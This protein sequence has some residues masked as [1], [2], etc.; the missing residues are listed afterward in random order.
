MKKKFTLR[1][2]T[3]GKKTVLMAV[4][5]LVLSAM[6]SAQSP[7]SNATTLWEENFGAGTEASSHPDA[8]FNYNPTG[9]LFDERTYRVANNLQQKIEWH[10]SADHTGNTNGNMLVVNGDAGDF[11]SHTIN[12][13]AG[14][15]SGS[16]YFRHFVINANVPYACFGNPL[17]AQV[18]LRAEY[19]DG[20]GN[21]V[22]MINS[23]YTTG[24]MPTSDNPVWLQRGATFD[25]PPA[26]GFITNIRITLSDATGGGCGND[27]A[28][29]DLGMYYCPDGGPLP[30]NFLDI[31]ASQKS[32]RVLVEWKTAFEINN[33]YFEIERSTDGISW[34]VIGR[35]DSKGNSQQVQSY[36]FPDAKPVIGTNIY[37][38]RQYDID[39]RS[40]LSKNASVKVNISRTTATVLANPFVNNLSVEF[41]SKTNQQV[42]VNLFDIAGKLVTTEKWNIGNGSTIK[43]V[44][45]AGNIERGIYILTITGESNEL[46][47]KGKVV[48]Q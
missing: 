41:L 32:T 1:S 4:S 34:T 33:R 42:N 20:S 21:W 25:L 39:G 6:A 35:V 27:F 16:Y 7:C 48:K 45:K 2:F 38:I 46:L 44:A 36:N 5:A 37:R 40:T 28:V 30:V 11:Y 47:Y 23:P 19:Q 31:T 14:F 26:A 12:R 3:A 13:T 18:S 10:N 43:N 22:S 8:L 29:D 17:L 15:P 9:P 24:A